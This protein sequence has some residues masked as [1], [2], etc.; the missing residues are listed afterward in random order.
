MGF[1]SSDYLKVRAALLS[2]LLLSKVE[3]IQL[4]GRSVEQ[5]REFFLERGL[6]TLA[7]EDPEEERRGLEQRLV[8]VLLKEAVILIRPLTGAH[9][10]FLTYWIHRFE[11]AN[12]KAIIRGRMAG[13]QAAAIRDRLLDMGPFAT[14][15]VEDLLRAEGMTDLL[16]RLESTHYSDIARRARRV[17]EEHH[18]LF[19]LDTIFDQRYYRG[20]VRRAGRIEQP[21][22]APA[23]F[24]EL[25]ATI[26]DGANLTWLMRYRFA[27][28]L[29]SAQ[30]Y[31]LLIPP[32]YRLRAG[33]VQELLALG[34]FEEALANLPSPFREW[35]AHARHTSDVTHILEY[36][37]FHAAAAMVR[38]SA[39]PF[40]RAFAY[41]ILRERDL[42]QVRSVIKGKRLGI[43]G[44]VVK[45]AL[46]LPLESDEAQP[47]GT[48]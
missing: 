9:R 3:L 39:S 41:L 35:L 34:T 24:R 25:M 22:S 6:G 31:F 33:K 2:R 37:T 27:Y 29:P 32:G 19:P 36:K 38:R 5:S 11:L 44:D 17:F 30:V 15:P 7:S 18:Q 12:L 8:T 40:V 14:L 13:E 46:G 16:L 23:D 4:T 48:A 20:L 45:E 28:Q 1:T 10:E 21:S 26:I 47:W 42:R 43:A